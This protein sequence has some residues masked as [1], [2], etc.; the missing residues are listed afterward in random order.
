MKKYII[1]CI[2]TMNKIISLVK[3]IPHHSACYST[4]Y[5]F[6]RSF[7]FKFFWC[8]SRTKKSSFCSCNWTVFYC[9]F[10][11]FMWWDILVLTNISS[12]IK[13]I[14]FRPFLL[15]LKP[16][17]LIFL[18]ASFVCYWSAPQIPLQLRLKLLISKLKIYLIF[19]FKGSGARCMY[20]N[21]F[22]VSLSP[23]SVSLF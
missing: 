18:A 4:C 5:N 13:V 19:P 10:I 2:I 21:F 8:F 1:V 14:S 15:Y 16:L 3:I 22:R 11:V 23:D 7:C 12:V 20:K 6:S 9:F 17:Q